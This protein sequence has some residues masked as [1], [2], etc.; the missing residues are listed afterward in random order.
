MKIDVPHETDRVIKPMYPELVRID[1]EN[2]GVVKGLKEA[3]WIPPPEKKVEP[4][5]FRISDGGKYI[6]QV[7][8]CPYIA[9]CFSGERSRCRQ[10]VI[11]ANFAKLFVDEMRK[12]AIPDEGTAPMW[13][14]N[15]YHDLLVDLKGA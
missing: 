13:V 1:T 11:Q 14:L 12:K 3:G 9:E 15:M 10:L 7:N 6:D 8:H 2:P 5:E 4:V